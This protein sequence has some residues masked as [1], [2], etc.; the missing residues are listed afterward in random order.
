M[1]SV[2]SKA[3]LLVP[4]LL[5]LSCFQE[6]SCFF[7]DPPAHPPIKPPVH[8]NP[9][10]RT[11]IVVQGV[12]YCKSCKDTLIGAKPIFGAVVKLLCQNTKDSVSVTATTDKNGYFFLQPPLTVISFA[13]Q[14]CKVFLV[15]SPIPS[16]SQ[17]SNLNGGLT[18]VS[19]KWENP[20]SIK[21][22]FILYSVGPFA[23]EPKCTF[24]G[25]K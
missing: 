19:L 25:S 21:L 5:L 4:L 24:P 20:S 2:P 23:F 12:V 18:G 6:A 3:F 10:L 1:E 11:Y 15:S 9:S 13:F 17:P 22:P 7:P 8:N 14:K 16:C